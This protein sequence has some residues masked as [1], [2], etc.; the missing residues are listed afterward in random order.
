TETTV[1]ATY[2]FVDKITN[3]ASLIPIGKPLANTSIYIMD[4]N[5]NLVPIG[6]CGEIYIG[7]EGNARGYLN[8]PELTAERFVD[9]HHSKLYK[10]GDLGR[11]LPDGHIEFVGRVDRQVKI[12]GFRLELG[13]IESR[14][15][16]H[17][18]V[19]EAVVAVREDK[20]GDKYLCAYIVPDSGLLPGSPKF[21]STS[22][23]QDD[24]SK[25]LPQ[26]M[27][28]AYFIPIEKIPLTPNGK[29]DRH[30]LPAPEMEAGSVYAPPGD[31]LEN[32]LVAI[33]TETLD[34]AP[35][36]NKKIGIDDNFFQIG[37]H[38]LKAA[39]VMAKI[40]KRLHARITMEDVFKYSTI[41]ELAQFI[42]QAE[43][44]IFCPINPVEDKEYYALSSAQKRMYV[45]QQMDKEG[46]TYHITSA[47]I[48]QGIPDKNKIENAL[49]EIIHRHESL[50]TSFLIV[51]D[52]PVQRIHKQ[53]NFEI[54]C[55]AADV[56]GEHGPT[57]AFDLEK[58]PLMRVSLVKLPG[59]KYLLMIGMHHIISDGM[60]MD[61]LVQDFVSY[62]SGHELPEL[63]IQYKDYAGWQNHNKENQLQYE[64]YW[65][66][67]FAGEIPILTLP[68]DYTRPI[69][70]GFA[71]AHINF[72]IDSETVH[73]LKSLALETGVTLYQVLLALYAI[74]LAKVGSQEDIVIGTPVA[75]RGHSDLEKIIGMFVNTLA[76]RNFPVGE[77]K[78][79]HFLVEVKER[80]L[81][82]FENQDYPYEELVEKIVPNRDASRNPLFDTM[83]IL[84]NVDNQIIDIPG[85]KLLPYEYENNTAKFD[86]TLVGIEAGAKLLFTFEYSTHLFKP[87]TIDRF[88][89][90]FKKV[91]A[92][93]VKNKDQRISGIEIISKEEKAHI[94]E[95]FNNTG[96]KYPQDKTI[97][98]LFVE[99]MEKTP[100]H[101]ALVG[102]GSQTC[103]IAISY[104]ELNA[105]SDR[106]AGSLIEKGIRGDDIIGTM[107]ERSIEMIIGIF[108]ILK[109]G[110]AYMPID[111]EYPQE[112]ID[113][114]LK[115]SGAKWLV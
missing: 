79:T 4:K 26:Y 93:I 69:V 110:G 101:I 86:L 15:L 32:E 68:A 40:H 47:W 43:E 115:D 30:A 70:Q 51:N 61:V 37:G 8:N 91:I 73:I 92:S 11:R 76:L 1:Y 42:R 12:R 41:R 6:A 2:Y 25:Q 14:L 22:Q 50:R 80:L 71:G 57:R 29:V 75:G 54:E 53:V 108:G 52:E 63:K 44:S 114:M 18:L 39:M 98:Q 106:W 33:W 62:Y 81:K 64:S 46:T 55:L 7:G 90:Y 83:F 96:T 31:S 82:A 5:M 36:S 78:W 16:K 88:I 20:T 65:Q 99:Q 95:N 103:P 87:E 19:K 89:L 48:L 84:Q 102:A 77:K 66:E 113:Y 74:F 34:H 3:D 21:F 60:S 38:S 17:E 9:F 67:Q 85:L 72:E 100:D 97:H 94:L 56:T 111:P 35:G 59:E 105:Q 107:M 58:A 10:T 23:L 28:P 24:L 45:L 13:E 112:R 104:N 109:S 49:R 27:I